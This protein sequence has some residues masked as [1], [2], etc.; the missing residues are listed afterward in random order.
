MTA[1]LTSVAAAQPAA[2]RVHGLVVDEAG[3]PVA[4]ATILLGGESVV[5]DATARSDRRDAARSIVIAEGYATQTV[6]R[7]RG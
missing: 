7:R 4:G 6:A 1:M 5:T 3:V 2:I